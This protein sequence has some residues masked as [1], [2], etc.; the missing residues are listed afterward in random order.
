MTRREEIL[1]NEKKRRGLA[2]RTKATTASSDLFLPPCTFPT[3]FAIG[4]QGAKVTYLMQWI[5][6]AKAKAPG[7]KCQGLEGAG[8]NVRREK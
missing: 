2:P 8:R 6:G 4:A 7:V 1:L 3:C 5:E